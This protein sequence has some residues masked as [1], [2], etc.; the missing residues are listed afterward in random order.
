MRVWIA[1]KKK[2][3]ELH[4]RKCNNNEKHVHTQ[5]Y[6]TKVLEGEHMSTNSNYICIRSVTDYFYILCSRQY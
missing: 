2:E 4:G 3:R 1:K 6:I 5:E